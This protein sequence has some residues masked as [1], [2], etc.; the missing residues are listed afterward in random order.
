VVDMQVS[1][2]TL[3]VG[4]ADQLLRHACTAEGMNYTSGRT[5]EEPFEAQIQVRYRARPV[6]GTIRPAPG[7]VAHVRLES[8]V[9]AVA[10]GQSLALYDG[11]RVI[12]GGTIAH[13]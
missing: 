6:R 4:K 13:S 1:R 5:P 12:G 9:R 10:P 7:S 8:P 3:I 11:D 2:N